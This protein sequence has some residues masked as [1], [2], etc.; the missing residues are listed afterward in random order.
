MGTT[1][2]VHFYDEGLKKLTCE[3]VHRE[4]IVW[5]RRLFWQQ[6]HVHKPAH[7]L[8]I[9]GHESILMSTMNDFSLSIN[10]KDP[11]HRSSHNTID[12]MRISNSISDAISPTVSMGNNSLKVGAQMFF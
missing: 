11:K 10:G 5:S 8:Q 1:A 3:E 2:R 7:C 4:W 9:I 12:Q 6:A